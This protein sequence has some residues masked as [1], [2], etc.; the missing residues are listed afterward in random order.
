MPGPGATPEWAS[1]AWNGPCA[2]GAGADKHQTRGTRGHQVRTTPS[3]RHP[4][5]PALCRAPLP[6]GRHRR[7]PSWPIS[8]VKNFVLILWF[9]E[10]Y[11]CSPPCTFRIPSARSGPPFR[12]L[13]EVDR[14]VCLNG[15]TFNGSCPAPRRG[16]GKKKGPGRVWPRPAGRASPGPDVRV[17]R[18]TRPSGR[19]GLTRRLS[20]RPRVQGRSAGLTGTWDHTRCSHSALSACKVS[21]TEC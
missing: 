15:C 5:A 16:P 19:L 13:S 2:R 11:G 3:A 7:P 12:F 14:S 10:P 18:E 1:R 4:P 21:G 8:R 17:L 9:R 20:P 6:P